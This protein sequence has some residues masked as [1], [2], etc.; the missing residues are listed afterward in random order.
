MS[1]S[2][3]LAFKLR[4]KRTKIRHLIKNVHYM[5]QLDLNRIK[6]AYFIVDF[7]DFSQSQCLRSSLARLAICHIFNNSYI[8]HHT[9]Y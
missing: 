1:F 3:F 9:S 6:I 2:L 4:K 7:K 8:F 5:I